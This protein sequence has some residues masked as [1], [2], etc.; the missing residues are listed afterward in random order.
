MQPT[1]SNA[2]VHVSVLRE[3]TAI[4]GVDHQNKFVCF[5]F[6]VFKKGFSFLVEKSSR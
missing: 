6:L 2:R 1:R 3:I 5:D 4:L